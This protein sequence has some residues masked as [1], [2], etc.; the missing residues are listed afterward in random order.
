[1][2]G[3]LFELLNY[4]N[5]LNNLQLIHLLKVKCI[6]VLCKSLSPQKQLFIHSSALTFWSQQCS[7]GA[8][9]D[10]FLQICSH[11][12]VFGTLS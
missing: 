6:F 1:M 10:L 8:V 4:T 5:L 3:R 12:A 2:Q 11:L 7:V 9:E